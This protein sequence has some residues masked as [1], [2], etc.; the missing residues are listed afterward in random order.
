[1]VERVVPR[2][3]T[4]RLLLR[5]WREAD[6]EPFRRMNADPVVMEHFVSTLT[7]AQSDA[8]VDHIVERWREHGYGLWALER[9]EDGEFIG[10]AGLAFQTFEAHFT[11][12]VEVGWRLTTQAWGH[13]YA[14]EAG[15]GAVAF[16]R[17]TL[18]LPE[19]V[20]FTTAGN[21]RSRRVMERLGM[22]YDPAEDFDYPSIPVGH[23]QRR[24]VLYRIQL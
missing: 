10:F 12:A 3:T 9:L 8:F 18:R 24:H 13:G 17:D 16:A 21:V 22:T 6:R 5:E 4:D 23:P 19:L 11:P 14:T 2:I 1:V 7:P 20:S 15:A